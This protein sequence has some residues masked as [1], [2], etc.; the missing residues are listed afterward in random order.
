MGRSKKNK[1]KFYGNR[2]TPQ[3]SSPTVCST[4]VV[5]T[6]TEDQEGLAEAVEDPS[7]P[8]PST[9]RAERT[10]SASKISVAT[11]TNTEFDSRN[12]SGNR[13]MNIVNILKFLE[14]LSCS[15]CLE[16]VVFVEEVLV[17]QA[18]TLHFTCGCESRLVLK[19]SDLSTKSKHHQLNDRLQLSIFEIGCHYEAARK[20]CGSMDLPPPVS[21]KSWNQNKERIHDAFKEEA[22]KSTERAASEI[23]EAKGNDVTVSCDGTWQKRG[24][25][26]KNGVVTVATVNGL[27]SKII[28]TETLTN[29]C[30]KCKSTKEN[31][32]IPHFCQKNYEGTAGSMEGEGVKRIFNRSLEQYDLTYT[33]YLG[34]GDS[35]SF[36]NLN[37]AEP[38]IY[39]GKQIQKLECVGHIQKRMGRKLNNLVL[40]CKKR[41][42]QDENGKK[43]KG[44]GGKN[45]LTKKE[46]YRIQ[47]H[48]GAAIR[49][50]VGNENGM[51]NAIWAIYHHRSG[52]HSLCGDWCPSKS[53]NLEKANARVLPHHV[54]EEMKP[55]FENLTSSELL[56]RCT[57]GGTQNVNESFHHIIWSLCPKEVFVGWRRLDIA[58]RSAI[59]QYNDGKASKVAVFNYMGI[60]NGSYHQQYV[61]LIDKKRVKGSEV[62]ERQ[63]KKRQ[64]N[65]E[66]VSLLRQSS[67]YGPG[68]CE[69]NE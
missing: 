17:G 52:D 38:P 60:Q 2:F 68:I 58:V 26:S 48:Y 67:E 62:T 61:N 1:R 30:N 54:L 53:G 44:I 66:A 43:S 27:N 6:E 28:D 29:H 16:Q 56:S 24:F 32:Q 69:N 45:K 50:H 37:D 12:I 41:T 34:D 42:Y 4:P 57:H 40:E 19:S 31:N 23:K 55:V 63:K 14:Q 3:N 18:S 5:Q 51:R 20:F 9:S 33:G 7:S 64:K 10:A 65:Q 39:P 22:S 46:I 59:M 11:D 15:A 25:S 35:K 8:M 36:K 49:K 21:C 13:I 47:G